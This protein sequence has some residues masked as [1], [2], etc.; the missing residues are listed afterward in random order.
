MSVQT[1]VMVTGIEQLPESPDAESL[2]VMVK[3]VGDVVIA[4]LVTEPLAVELS[5][6]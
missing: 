4:G 5:G 2:T 1:S 6:V 3:V